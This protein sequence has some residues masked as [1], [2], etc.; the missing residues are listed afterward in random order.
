M[1]RQEWRILSCLIFFRETDT[2]FPHSQPVE[3]G[4]YP[5]QPANSLEGETQ[6]IA[7]KDRREM[8]QIMKNSVAPGNHESPH[9]PKGKTYDS[10]S[11]VLGEKLHTL[12]AENCSS[13]FRKAVDG[14][15]LQAGSFQSSSIHSMVVK[16]IQF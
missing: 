10:H 9:L 4:R 13:R 2:R 7:R 3:R 6:R 5:P 15:H 8:C 11:H 16:T 1:K 14:G 12:S